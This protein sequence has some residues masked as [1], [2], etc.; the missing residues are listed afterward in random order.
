ML[1]H[2]PPCA[3]VQQQN[4]RT[5][6]FLITP[7]KTH[8]K[9]SEGKF[10]YQ[11]E[12]KITKFTLIK[13]NQNRTF[14]PPS[15]ADLVRLA[16]CSLGNGWVKMI[17]KNLGKNGYD[18]WTTPRARVMDPRRRPLATWLRFSGVGNFYAYVFSRGGGCVAS[19]CTLFTKTVRTGEGCPVIGADRGILRARDNNVDKCWRVL[20][21]GRRILVETTVWS[22]KVRA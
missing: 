9:K 2:L 10:W 3:L 21:R 14:L 15:S 4:T 17:I 20:G 1:E 16:E 8:S 13:T 6:P 12:N 18:R 19:L 22:I 5:D 7:K 11:L